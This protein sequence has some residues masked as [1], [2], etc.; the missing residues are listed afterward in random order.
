MSVLRGESRRCR[1]GQ[2]LSLALLLQMGILR[3][4]AKGVQLSLC[5]P[6]CQAMGT[7]KPLQVL[8]CV[9]FMLWLWSWLTEKPGSE[10]L[11][12]AGLG[13]LGAVPDAAAVP[14]AQEGEQ[15][16]GCNAWP[17]LKCAAGS[18]SL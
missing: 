1:K 10:D 14:P 9:L 15:L 2:H 6:V 18:L 7:G 16:K 8:K 12:P 3:V 4:D 17:S 5:H 13:C 11:T